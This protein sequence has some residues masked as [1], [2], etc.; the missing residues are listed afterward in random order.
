MKT[1]PEFSISSVAQRTG[2]AVS[3][4]R[5]YDDIG[6][7]VSNRDRAG[8]RRFPRSVIRQLSF[9]IVL[10]RFGFS[11]ARIKEVLERLPDGRTPTETDWTRVASEIRDEIDER[12]AT[13]ERIRNNL[14][15]CIGCGC[16]SLKR[17][18]IFN[19]DDRA[20]GLGDGP[21]YLSGNSSAEVTDQSG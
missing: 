13:L 20:S 3:A 18:A 9:I 1:D 21:R 11:L 6:L 14:D 12:I 17:C 10:Q 19:P 16:L 8:R 4:L 15:G 2:L 7:I 5:Y